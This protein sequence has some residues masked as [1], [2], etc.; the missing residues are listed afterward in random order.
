LHIQKLINQHKITNKS[1]FISLSFAKFYNI[2][3][4]TDFI[5]ANI[6]LIFKE[7]AKDEC[8]DACK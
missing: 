2:I 3:I 4:E 8:G 1:L 5:N 7:R 6:A